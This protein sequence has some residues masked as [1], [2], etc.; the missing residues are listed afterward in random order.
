MKKLIYV[1]TLLFILINYAT[2]IPNDNVIKTF[3]G[4][5]SPSFVDLKN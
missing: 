4:A 2:A 3:N 5:Y 1:I